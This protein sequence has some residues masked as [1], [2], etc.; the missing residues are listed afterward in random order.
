MSLA[1][2]SA[3][4][5]GLPRSRQSPAGAAAAAGAG[6]VVVV[7]AAAAKVVKAASC[8]AKPRDWLADRTLIASR[9]LSGSQLALTRLA[10]PADLARKQRLLSAD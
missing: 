6:V 4:S 2:S 8:E 5:A 1:S 10:G 3:C 9:R 7:V